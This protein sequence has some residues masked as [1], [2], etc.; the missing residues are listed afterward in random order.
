M[1]ADANTANSQE[2]RQNDGTVRLPYGR[3]QGRCLNDPE[4][5]LA[6]LRHLK[7]F[8]W[9]VD[10]WEKAALWRDIEAEIDRRMAGVR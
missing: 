7:N 1:L 4:I 9:M 5:P 10:P 6:Y 3:F 2:S 8:S